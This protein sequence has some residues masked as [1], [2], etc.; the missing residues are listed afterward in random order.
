MGGVIAIAREL[1]LR[2]D[3]RET[4]R[5]PGRSVEQRSRLTRQDTRLEEY[6]DEGG[7]QI[8]TTNELPENPAAS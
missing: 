7:D 3:V 5:R 8:E 2:L 6:I 4:W 1:Q